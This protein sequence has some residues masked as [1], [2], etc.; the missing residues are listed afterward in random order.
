MLLYPLLLRLEGQP[1]LVVGGGQ[2]AERKIES[3]LEVGA[4]VT[5]ISPALTPEIQRWVDEDK[6]RCHLREYQDGDAAGHMVVIAAT[7]VSAVNEQVARDCFQRNILIN[8]VDI[9]QLCNFYVPAVVRRGDLTI[10]IST[11]G[12]SPAIARRI[13]EK[14][15]ATFGEEYCEYLQVMKSLREQVLREV[16]NPAR[17]K[18]IF[19]T[20]AEAELLECI[21][22]GDDQALKERIAQ[23]LSSS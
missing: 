12:C 7:D 19:E 17:R 23:C 5:V 2:V 1:C 6:L 11:N 13:R 20:L 18:A 15:E 4:R 9:P 14:L 10:A 16:P 22:A 8:T 3:L 21:Q